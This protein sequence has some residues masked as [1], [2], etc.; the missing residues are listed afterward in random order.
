MNGFGDS[1]EPIWL[2][3]SE[4]AE[5]AINAAGPY[6]IESASSERAAD[7]IVTTVGGTR[8]LV[9]WAHVIAVTQAQPVLEEPSE[10]ESSPEDEPDAP[11]PPGGFA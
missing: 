2:H 1:A 11:L 3:V 10:P 7:G 6:Q 4:L 8:Y 5:V 9:P